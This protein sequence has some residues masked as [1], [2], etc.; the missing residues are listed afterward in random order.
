MRV[1]RARLVTAALTGICAALPAFAQQF[2][3]SP[4]ADSSLP[5][6]PPCDVVFTT[7]NFAST[8]H[9]LRD[10][11]KYVFCVTPG[12]YRSNGEIDLYTSG[13]RSHRRF[14]RLNY[15]DGLQNAAQRSTRAIFESVRIMGD[16]WVIRQ[17]TIQPKDP[18]TTQYLAVTGGDHD[19]LEGNLVD[20]IDQVNPGETYG[21]MLNGGNGDPATYNTVQR[22]L[23]RNGN[24]QRRPVDY[25]GVMVAP[26]TLA[27]E[28]NDWNRVVDNEIID[29]GDGVALGGYT[30]D[31]SEPG[32]QHATVVDNN[33]IYLTSKK[34][35]D[36]T[37]G[38]ADPNGECTCAEN[39]IDTKSDPGPDPALWTQITNNRV[40]GYRPT[41][42]PS[43]GGSGANGQAITAGN[44]CPGHTVVA[45]NMVSDS[46][47]GI[48]IVGNS[49]IVTGNLV[50]NIRATT[51][52]RYG[53][54]AILA[55]KHGTGHR[56]SFNTLLNDDTAY[57]NGSASTL[58]RCNVTINDRNWAETAEPPGSGQYTSYNY[59]YNGSTTNF[60][61]ATNVSFA[62]SSQAKDGSYCYWRA[63]WSGPEQICVPNASTTAA[64]PHVKALS[65]CDPSELVA[66][67]GMAPVSWPTSTPCN[68]GVD[69]DGDGLTDAADPGCASPSSPREDPECDN[70]IDDDGDGLVDFDGGRSANHGVALAQPDPGCTSASQRRETGACGLGFEAGI[71]IVLIRLRLRKLV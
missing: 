14:L 59:L 13:T 57:D 52:W 66:Q 42:T 55:D 64:S 34:R 63:R 43:C 19:V 27:G 25:T 21:V 68:D 61:G 22:N 7:S 62:S 48:S 3:D 71:A 47:T 12:D 20:G 54:F 5:A 36:C 6:N 15:N 11:T 39:A 65:I 4:F 24:M 70:G 28:N 23:I 2:A 45:K 18:A 35:A 67:F 1:S 29:W 16:W 9:L 30:M 38:A 51:G 56:I 44:M 58:T 49:W 10:D 46:T 50:Y 41:A 17:L 31:C 60:P 32:R 40:W 69:N 26:A 33:D 8:R 53:S 37:T